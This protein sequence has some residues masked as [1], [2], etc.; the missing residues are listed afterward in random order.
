MMMTRMNDN[1]NKNFEQEIFKKRKKNQKKV[2]KAED[3][4]SK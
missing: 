2:F 3:D 4:H 1:E